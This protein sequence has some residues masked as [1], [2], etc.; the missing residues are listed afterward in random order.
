[1]VVTISPPANTKDFIKQLKRDYPAFNFKPGDQDHWSPKS[2]TITYNKAEPLTN[3]CCGI[4]HELAHA[5]LDH[6]S[7]NSDFELVKLESEAWTL[8]AQIGRKYGVNIDDDHIQNCLDTYRDWLHRR[9]ACPKCGTH[10]LQKDVKH[11]Q[12][13]NCQASWQVS[14]GRFVR[15][16]RR[17]VRT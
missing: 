9:S 3:M 7:Y 2:Q 17:S 16:Y 5:V 1:M 11:Y 13:Y 15:P 8:A 6:T 12:C 4:L 14:A 10:V